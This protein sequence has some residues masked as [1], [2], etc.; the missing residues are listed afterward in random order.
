[1]STIEELDFENPE[2]CP[3]CGQYVGGDSTCPNCGAIL[4]EEDD[5]NIFEEDGGLE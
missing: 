1:M 3:N 4:F 2:S 5:L